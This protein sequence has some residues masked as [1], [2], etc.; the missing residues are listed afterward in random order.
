MQSGYLQGFI[1]WHR[2]LLK[3]FPFFISFCLPV[4]S[5]PNFRPDTGGRGWSLIRVAGSLAL[6]GGEG[7]ALVSPST[8][9]RLPAALYG[10]GPAL[11]VVAAFPVYAAQAA[12]YGAGPA[13]HAVAALGC[14]TKA[15]TRLRLCFVPSPGQAAQAARSLTGAFPGCGAPSALSVP[16]PSPRPRRSGACALCLAVTLPADV[17]HPESQEVF[18]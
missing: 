5:V 12:L 8:L 16:S 3:R 6:R 9:L 1:L 17:A 7:L 14:S 13:L 11:R 4:S 10:A 15:R 2:S 18:G